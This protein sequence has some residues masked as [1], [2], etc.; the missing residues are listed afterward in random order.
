MTKLY[1]VKGYVR[2]SPRRLSPKVVDQSLR[3]V[4]AL[5]YERA[6]LEAFRAECG[7]HEIEQAINE[8]TAKDP[9]FPLHLG[10]V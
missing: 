6:D 10:L 4:A 3:V 7:C 1:A 9:T 2:C 8:E 5:K